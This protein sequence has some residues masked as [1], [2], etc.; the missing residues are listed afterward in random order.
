MASEVSGQ[1]DAREHLSPAVPI[2]S[3]SRRSLADES[4]SIPLSPELR[5]DLLDLDAWGEILATYGR[6]MRVAVALTDAQGHVLGKCHN[7]Q[8][9]WT[10]VHDVAG[11]PSGCPFCITTRSAMYCGGGGIAWWRGGDGAGPGWTRPCGGSAVIGQAAFR[12]HCRGSG[13][14]SIS[15]A[16]AVA[17]RGQEVWRF[18]AGTLEC[19]EKAASRKRRDSPGIGRFALCSGPGISPATLWRD[20]RG[21]VGRDKWTLSLAGGGGSGLC[22]LHPGPNRARDQLE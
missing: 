9:V 16:P 5:A 2:P 14:R 17:A 1:V 12:G 3:P 8:P 11:W 13:V 10:L 7:A 6:T 19:G 20:P 22:A 4:G 18:G 21:Q 15:R